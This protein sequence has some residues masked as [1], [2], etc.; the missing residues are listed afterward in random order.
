MRCILA[1]AIAGSL[2]L[3]PVH[4]SAGSSWGSSDYGD[5]PGVC[6][7]FSDMWTTTVVTNDPLVG[8]NPEQ[9]PFY[10]FHPTPG[11]DDWYGYFYGDS[12][13]SPGAAAGWTK[14]LHENYPSHF[15]WNFATNG[16]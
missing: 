3:Q 13:G 4:A 9:D 5:P 14:L 7:R 8:T 16:W 11:Y 1:V 12:R 15:R 2:A 6:T 10:G